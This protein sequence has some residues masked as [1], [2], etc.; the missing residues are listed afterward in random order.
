MGS[1]TFAVKVLMP[2]PEMKI[3]AGFFGR[4][5]LTSASEAPRPVVPRDAVVTR[6]GGSHVV[7]ARDGKA[8]VVP[9]ERGLADGN[10][11][12]VG[13]DLKEGELV[14]TRGNEALRGGE[15]LAVQPPAATQPVAGAGG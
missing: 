6:S 2:N 5:V 13:G 1:R 7:V 4:A 11:I 8:V 9:V 10:M 15:P 14:V 3:R 12:A